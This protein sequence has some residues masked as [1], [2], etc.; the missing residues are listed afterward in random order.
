MYM[1]INTISTR[2]I[3]LASEFG[4]IWER[5]SPICRT[6]IPRL[7]NNV[8][9]WI[10]LFSWWDAVNTHCWSQ[11]AN[12]GT[13]SW[14][15]IWVACLISAL[16]LWTFGSNLA[17]LVRPSLLSGGSAFVFFSICKNSG[18]SKRKNTA[19]GCAIRWGVSFGDSGGKVLARSS[20]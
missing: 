4:D 3:E 19:W 8:A 20:K 16:W 18:R 5:T 7:C 9:N 10:L 2:R 6:L 11:L 17:Q 1:Y 13:K 12:L 14:I 15:I